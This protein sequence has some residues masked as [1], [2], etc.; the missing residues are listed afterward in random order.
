MAAYSLSPL[1]SLRATF[2]KVLATFLMTVKICI[3]GDPIA[4]ET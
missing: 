3:N 4:M 1:M 2:P